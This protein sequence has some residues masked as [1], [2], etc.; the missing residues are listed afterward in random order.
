METDLQI[1][2]RVKE[3]LR[4]ESGLAGQRIQVKVSNGIVTLTG[5]VSSHLE[6]MFAEKTASRVQGVKG[7]EDKLEIKVPAAFKKSDEEIKNAV[8]KVIKWNSGVTE[9]CIMVSVKNGHVTLSGEVQWEYQKTRAKSL[10]ED[11]SGVVAVKN[12]IRVVTRRLAA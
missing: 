6:K 2:K 7:V 11:V 9:D 8:S 12:L 3:E 4:F 5:F 10:A 1:E